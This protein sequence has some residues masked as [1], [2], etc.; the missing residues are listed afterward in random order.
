[1]ET[2]A[3]ITG[4]FQ[5]GFGSFVDKEVMPFISEIIQDNCQTEN[6]PEPYSFHHSLP[7][8]KNS[9][10]F[11]ESV[12]KAR[13]SGEYLNDSKSPISYSI[14]NVEYSIFILL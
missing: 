4:D 3:R 8:T 10:V 2:L 1:M 9:S 13:I 12:S 5:I 14:F 6:C 7:L 11:Q